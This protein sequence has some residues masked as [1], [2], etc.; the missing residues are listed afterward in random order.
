MHSLFIFS[1]FS[2]SRKPVQINKRAVYWGNPSEKSTFKE[3]SKLSFCDGEM[4]QNFLF[5]NIYDF[6]KKG[7]ILTDFCTKSE[8]L[9]SCFQET[10][11]LFSKF[12]VSEILP[13]DLY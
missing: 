2:I 4:N 7:Q 8:D 5:H 1:K 13:F 10:F 9:L 12:L 6:S 11:G 3:I